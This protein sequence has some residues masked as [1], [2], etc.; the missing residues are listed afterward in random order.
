MIKQ[1]LSRNSNLNTLFS[2]ID[3][4]KNVSI[5]NCGEGEQIAIL[6]EISRPKFFVVADKEE[7]IKY[8]NSFA[9]L[10]YKINC[11]FDIPSLNLASYS[12]ESQQYV[13]FINNLNN[14]DYDIHIVT[15]NVAMLPVP[16]SIFDTSNSI[17][18]AIDEE[19]DRDDFIDFLVNIGYVK[20]DNISS[21]GQFCCRGEIVDVVLQNDTTGYRVIFDY[22]TIVK[23]SVLDENYVEA[24]STINSLVIA[25][26]NLYNPDFDAIKR[27]FSGKNTQLKQ[28]L[29]NY[30][31]FNKTYNN[32]WFLQ[33]IE[34]QLCHC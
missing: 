23:I 19:L 14:P 33:Y 6:D 32:L 27:D 34:S 21:S 17:T 5:F 2:A 12:S 7:G 25:D 1:L 16:K 28:M 31:Q 15:P 11:C 13:A 20:C 4:N 18:L 24:V 22:D 3:N 26:S 8:A 10:N 29:D 9:K 30:C